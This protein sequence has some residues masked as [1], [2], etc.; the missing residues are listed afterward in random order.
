MLIVC[1]L[2]E[3]EYILREGEPLAT[4]SKFYMIEEG[5]VECCKTIQVRRKLQIICICKG[6]ID[7]QD[8]SETSPVKPPHLTMLHLTGLALDLL[9][10]FADIKLTHFLRLIS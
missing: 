10:P 2:Q 5:L 6:S 1:V 4:G 7:G 9:L 8:E 3:G